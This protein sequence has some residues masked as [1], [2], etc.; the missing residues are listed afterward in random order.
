MA[1]YDASYEILGT[2]CKCVIKFIFF[3]KNIKKSYKKKQ[4]KHIEKT[5]KQMKLKTNKNRSLEPALQ[6]VAP[7]TT[8]PLSLTPFSFFLS[9][10]CMLCPEW[11]LCEVVV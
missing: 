11:W 7:C 8:L 3:A 1:I 6:R 5:Q 10:M 9:A 4:T 2:Q